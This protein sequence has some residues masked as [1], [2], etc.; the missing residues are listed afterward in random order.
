MLLTLFYIF[1]FYIPFQI[2]LN[3][4]QD[5]DLMSGRVLILILFFWWLWTVRK[6][7]KSTVRRLLNFQSIFLLIFLFLATISVFWAKETGWGIRK[8]LVFY[9]IFPLYFLTA[10]LVS[11]QKQIEK[12][13]KILCFSSLPISLVGLFQFSSQ[14]IFLTGHITNFWIKW[15]APVFYGRAFGWLVSA[16]PSWMFEVGGRFYFRAISIFPDP[17]TFSFYLGL[18]IPLT[19]AL[20]VFENKRRKFFV[21]VLFC[22]VLCVL[23]TFSRGGYLAMAAFFVLSAILFIK[24]KLWP[25]IQRRNFLTPK[26]IAVFS[27]FVLIFFVILI[28]ITPISKCFY[29]SFDFSRHS[30][31]ERM[32]IWLEAMDSIAAHPWLGVGIGN[33]PKVIDPWA[34]YLSPINAHSTYLDIASEM[35]IFTLWVWLVLF[36]G[37]IL[38]LVKKR[39]ILFFGIAGSLFWFSCHAMVEVPIYNSTILAILMVL[40]GL[41]TVALKKQWNNI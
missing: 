14:F 8:I 39:N 31:A 27:F 21:F 15:I 22:Q 40:F 36:F 1:L 29:S 32:E 28:P 2:A 20:V 24:T 23:F 37:T 33:F 16:N 4:Y 10:S 19:M 18:M 12:I 35:G 11:D 13:I 3:P 38:E 5:I 30:N 6:S 34:K 17:H 41:A 26:I 25:L 7:L 9:S